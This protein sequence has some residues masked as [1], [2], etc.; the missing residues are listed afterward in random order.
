MILTI[1][2]GGGGRQKRTTTQFVIRAPAVTVTRLKLSARLLFAFAQS[3]GGT[4]EMRP[5]L[6]KQYPHV[7]GVGE[8]GAVALL[9]WFRSGIGLTRRTLANPARSGRK[10]R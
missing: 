1:H 9:E 4:D 8:S 5:S 2:L 7:D 6:H 3:Y 10:Q